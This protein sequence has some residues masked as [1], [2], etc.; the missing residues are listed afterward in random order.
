MAAERAPQNPA[1]QTTASG[2]E[3]E[4][5]RGAVV[6]HGLFG[7]VKVER[8]HGQ[9]F[10][11]RRYAKDGTL[12]RLLWYNQ[13]RLHSTLNYVT[14]RQFEQHWLAAKAKQASP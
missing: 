11:T 13:C 4:A 3:G 10:V 9:R 6:F 8:V 2:T 1:T 7:P 12:A 5:S 14:L